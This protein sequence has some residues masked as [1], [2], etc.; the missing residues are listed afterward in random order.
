MDYDQSSEMLMAIPMEVDM[1]HERQP[2]AIDTLG[3][4]I[5]E[6]VE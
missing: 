4:A 1:V 2:D 6:I 5:A 3:Y